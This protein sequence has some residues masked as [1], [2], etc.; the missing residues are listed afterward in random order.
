MPLS[1][2]ATDLAFI[3]LKSQPHFEMRKELVDGV[4]YPS[5]FDTKTGFKFQCSQVNA[6]VTF[7]CSV[8]NCP[9]NFTKDQD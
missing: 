1:E 3:V 6:K 7:K 9:A 5:L 2:R 8:E 4:F